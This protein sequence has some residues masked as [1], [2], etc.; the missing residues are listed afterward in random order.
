MLEDAGALI[1]ADKPTIEYITLFLASKYPG[2]DI[3]LSQFNM[4][5]ATEFEYYIR[6]SPIKAD[7]PCFGLKGL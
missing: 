2:G 6:N 1:T 4:Q 3:Y 5:T 7:D